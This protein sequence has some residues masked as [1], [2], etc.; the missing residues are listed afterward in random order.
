MYLHTPVRALVCTPRLQVVLHT[1]F[2][3]SVSPFSRGCNSSIVLARTHQGAHAAV[4]RRCSQL[5][6]KAPLPPAGGVALLRRL[7]WEFLQLLACLAYGS[8]ATGLS[9]IPLTLSMA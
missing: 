3:S 4:R 5:R 1:P 9:L 6:P 8:R 7:R 2:F